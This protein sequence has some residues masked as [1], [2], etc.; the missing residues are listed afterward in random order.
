MHTLIKSLLFLIFTFFGV[1]V[2]AQPLS[3]TIGIFEYQ[4][5]EKVEQEFEPLRKYL[6][7]HLPGIQIKLNVLETSK[8]RQAVKRGEV[9]ALLVNPNLYELIRSENFLYGITATLEKNRNGIATASL[10]GV[11]FTN[12]SRSGI[13]TLHQ[14][15]PNTSIAV[16]SLNH[17]GA[18][19]VPLYELYKNE[20]DIE[21]LNFQ[22]VR[23]NDNVIKAVLNGE[24]QV[25][26]LRTGVLEEYVASR[27]LLSLEKFQILNE[28]HRNS[29]PYILSTSL[30]P[31]WPFII[32]PR[33]P[34]E[35]TNKITSLLFSIDQNT[36]E[37][38]HSTISGFITP[39]DYH[40]FEDLLRE[41]KLAPYDYD[42]LSW[43]EIW[44][45]HKYT[46]LAV[47]AFFIT[48][49]IVL[50]L[51]E[52]KRRE[53]Q[54]QKRI[55][56]VLISLPSAFEEMEE[57]EVMQFAMEQIE[58]LTDSKISFIHFLDEDAGEIQLIA[59]SHRTLE[60]YCHV[61]S[62]ETHYPI[63]SAG[64]W[65]EAARH[66]KAFVIN[67]YKKYPH[68][69]GLPAGHAQLK[70][71]VSLPVFDHKKIVILAG[72]GN[73]AAKYT[74]KDVNTIQ[75][76]L[77]EV[78][79]LIK[80]RRNH[81]EIAEQKIKFQRLLDD[82]GDDYMVFAHNGA[83]GILTYVSAGFETIFEKPV[84]SVLHQPWFTQL[85]WTDESI[86]IGKQSVIE[87]LNGKKDKNEFLLTFKTQTGSIKHILVQ[88][89]GVYE[90]NHLVSVEGLVTDVTARIASEQKLKQAA[91]V[92][93][94][95]NE[96]ILICDRHNQIIQVNRT[97]ERITGYKESELLGKS[98]GMLS[99]G[100]KNNHIY[101]EIWRS[102]ETSDSWEGELQNHRKNGET[103]P[104]R[105]KITVIRDENGEVEQY[106]GLMSD[107]SHEKEFQSQLEKMAHHDALTGLPN[108]FL[109]SDRINQAIAVS[110]R[111][112]TMLAIIF[113]DLDGFKS[114]NDTFGHQA[115]DHLLKELASRF[116]GILR[117]E[118][119]VARIG[120]DEFVVVIANQS[121][122][123]EIQNIKKRLLESSVQPVEFEGDILKVSSSI[124][125]VFYEPNSAKDDIGSEK[126][127]RLADTA[128][129]KAKSLG[130]NQIYHHEWIDAG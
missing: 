3:F 70:R 1:N 114:I 104:E 128:M 28:Q 120:G 36:P 22:E 57:A 79:R 100:S 124:G 59:W 19:R 81:A 68:K 112:S 13:N 14:I 84:S 54:K 105:L 75:L 38:S 26:F 129:Y 62:Y 74:Q 46:A 92:F 116:Q 47:I 98:P 88:Q 48:L 17:T 90:N 107:I 117:E 97:F 96:G 83:E 29:Y 63:E 101:P 8:L 121:H 11:I 18:F 76:V 42:P 61:N 56:D 65:A 25:G 4:T 7:R 51:V 91:S 37:F 73:K 39:L 86:Q 44:N 113:I 60:A 78:W 34:K 33:V 93:Q 49:I 110:R 106:V 32:L 69:K 118:D 71:M 35:L 87:L 85:D 43:V 64:V 127:I 15:I 16:P 53:V 55:D 99:D 77:N 115:G 108:R 21:K 52:V 102:L 125:V 80:D 126:L 5:K 2:V 12:S 30:Y 82:L 9:D 50:V 123:E 27:P 40:P 66:R 6:D 109:L 122:L 130:K 10:G 45:R 23:T 111:K 72:V 89:N 103:Y 20:I 24:A 58:N 67:D 41:L 119:T 31:E 94:S 95:A